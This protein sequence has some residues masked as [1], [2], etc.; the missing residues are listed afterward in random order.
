MWA[1]EKARMAQINGLLHR[2]G[3][4]ESIWEDWVEE[5]DMLFD[6]LVKADTKDAALSVLEDAFN[7]TVRSITILTHLRVRAAFRRW[8]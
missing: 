7:D 5:T 2:S 8:T 6:E 1:R 4:D 3:Y